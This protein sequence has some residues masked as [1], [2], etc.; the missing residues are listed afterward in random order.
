MTAHLAAAFAVVACWGFAWGST[1]TAAEQRPAGT[2]MAAS[3]ADFGT[4]GREAARRGIDSLPLERI[5]PAHHDVI[6]HFRRSTTLHRR[7]PAETVHCD[8][9]LLAFL[10]AKPEAM[11]DM[12]RVLGIS[13]VS[14]DPVARGQWQ[15]SDGYGTVGVVRL[16]H[17]ERSDAGDMLILHGRGG[18]SGPLSPK[19]LSGSCLLVIRHRDLTGAGVRPTQEIEM[20]AFLDVDG[21]GFELVTRTLQPLIVRSAA[22]NF[23]EICLFVGQFSAAADRNPTGVARLANRMS[24][25]LPHDRQAL[26]SVACGRSFASAGQAGDEGR[27]AD[28]HEELAARWMPVEAIDSLRR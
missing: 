12:W 19:D 4:A 13:R 21:L 5:A 24:R 26:V 20:E 17:H 15:L 10:L 22:A 18:Y 1:A 9:E 3:L 14:L 2:G 16:L 7:L 8:G 23:H 25:T 27:S 11:V 6:A 28:F